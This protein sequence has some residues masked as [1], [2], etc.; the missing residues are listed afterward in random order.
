MIEVEYPG[1]AARR[2]IE[3]SIRMGG[4]VYPV[5]EAVLRSEGTAIISGTFI[6]GFRGRRSGEQQAQGSQLDDLILDRQQYIQT[7]QRLRAYF[8]RNTVIANY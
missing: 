3:T 5:G 4:R 6:P 7:V 1:S 8:A 2:K